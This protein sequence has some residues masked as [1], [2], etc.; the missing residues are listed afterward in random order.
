M[1]ILLDHPFPFLLAHGGFQIQIEQTMAA[2]NAIGLQAEYLQWWN[3]SQSADLVHYFGRPEIEYVRRLQKKGIKVVHAELLGGVGVRPVWARKI[4]KTIVTGSRFLPAL[5]TLRYR[6]RAF[7]LA[8]AHIALTDWE[9]RLMQDIFGAP[10]KKIHVVPNG[11]EEL[12]FS[13]QPVPRGKWLVC[14]ATLT[15]V[16]RVVE[17]AQAA[18]IA[19]TPVWFIGK[20]YTEADPYARRF[21]ELAAQ[22]PGVIRYEGGID[23]RTR[24][25]Q[26]CREARGFVLLSR[27]ESLSLSAL[28]AAAA[29]CP[30]LLS[31]LPWARSAFGANAS[32]VPVSPPETTAGHLKNFYAAAPSLPAPPRPL[33]WPEVAR[34][35]KTVYEKVLST[36]S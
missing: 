16:K 6:W 18:V 4:Q 27:L 11:V 10:A 31:D 5:L 28:E 34:Q 9:A 19:Q 3:P 2:L 23:D 32:Y 26:I 17:L 14:T 12:F 22:N 24:L 35:L 15:E 8:D 1:K 20:P 13:G 7:Q 25:A 36:A 30:L 29:G 21:R 33:T